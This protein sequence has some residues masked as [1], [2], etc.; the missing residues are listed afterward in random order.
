M[1]IKWWKVLCIGS[2]K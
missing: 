1:N 2:P